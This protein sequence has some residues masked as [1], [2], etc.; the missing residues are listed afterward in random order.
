MVDEGQ[1]LTFQ[2]YALDPHDPTYQLPTRNPDGSLTPPNDVS[3]IAYTVSGL[4]SGASYDPQTATFN[5]T[6]SYT[7]A[8]QYSI[9]VTATDGSDN[10]PPLST[11][12]IIPISVRIVDRSPQITPISNVKVN[13]GQTLDVPVTVSDPNGQA[14]TLTASNALTNAPLPGFVTFTDNGNGTGDFH[15][16]PTIYEPGNYSIV[17]SATDTGGSQGPGAAL[18]STYTFVV[19]VV[20]PNAPP[21]LAPINGQVA[22]VG[23]TFS[24]TTRASD[25]YQDALGYS[26]SGLPSSATLKPGVTYGTAVL[27]W[28]PTSSQTGS[29]SVTVTVTD[30]T[31]TSSPPPSDSQTFN[32]VVVTTDSAPVVT[33]PGNQS[34]A[35][36]APLNLQLQ[37]SDTYGNPVT[38]IATGLPGG[39]IL[40]PNTG[41]IT[42]AAAYGQAGTYPVTVSASDGSESSNA[43]FTITA[44]H[45]NRAPIL[46]PE[47]P[48]YGRENTGLSFNVAG[49]DP[50]G[51]AV[52]L[53]ASNLPAGATFNATTGAFQWTP[54]FGQAGDYTVTFTMTDQG[55]LSDSILVPIHIDH[56][57]RPPIL[58]IPDHQATLGQLLIFSAA[59]TNPNVGS[60]LT[61]SAQGLPQ[62]ASL[63]PNTGLVSWIPGPAQAGDY[64]VRFTASD[65]ILSTTQSVLIE[66]AVTPTP[67]SVTIVLSPNYPVA[68]GTV[69]TVHAIASSVAPITGVTLTL[70]GQ[71]VT[72]DATGKGQ[73]TAGPPG[74]MNLQAVATDADG[75]TGSTTAVLK[76]LDPTDTTAPVVSLDPSLSQSPL[77]SVTTVNGTVAGGNLD[78]WSLAMATLGSENF[79]T[80]A[81]GTAPVSDG[82]LAQ[83]DP[84]TLANGFY[85][86]QLT[87]T[88]IAGLR[89]VTTTQIEVDTSSKPSAVQ[90]GDTDLTVTLDGTTVNLARAYNS[91]APAGVSSFGPG[92]SLVSRDVF[93]Q[94]SL[95]PTG[96]ESLGVYP[97]MQQGTR[98][99]LT[100]PNGTRAGFTF[101]PVAVNLPDQPSNLTY[102]YPAWQADTGV[103]YQL[104]S[105]KTLLVRGGN[106][107][108]DQATGRSYNPSDPFFGPTGYTLTAPDDSQE[109][110]GA[111]GIAELI[112]ASG[113][114]LRVSSSG[115]TAADGETIRFVEGAQGRI[116]AA[117]APSGETINYVYATTGQLAEVVSSTRGVLYRYGYDATLGTLNAAARAAGG[118]RGVPGRPAAPGRAP[119]RRFRRC[120]TVR[121]APHRPEHAQGRRAGLLLLLQRRR[122]PQHQRRQRHC[123]R[124]HCAKRKRARGRDA[125][126][127]RADAAEPLRRCQP[128]RRALRDNA[129]RHLFAA[130]HRC[131]AGRPRRLHCE[132]GCGGRHQRRRPRGRHG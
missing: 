113:S 59:G 53:T 40:N 78:S 98:L 44:T 10:N 101:E 45:T 81:T 23:D 89:S 109:L 111:N 27:T 6:P 55:G 22:L 70:N 80:I 67:P 104:S 94:T 97:A 75:L 65:G 41:A 83:I 54:A 100:L 12:I 92:W 107:Y 16:A 7:Q 51:D 32:L 50:D 15:F 77:T 4:P 82:E 19:T 68:Q 37:A 60:T 76:I 114:V 131:D 8:G 1:K 5:W 33:A 21:L 123:A 48:Q 122:G 95:A 14:L 62:G 69:V 118:K 110:I 46:V 34:V 29:Y 108:Y 26:L 36:G 119:H 121:P 25:I 88:S 117:Q 35:E 73:I 120:G 90:V 63:D 24:L 2:T 115:I 72:L 13:G 116:I 66:A 126:R 105:V 43:S 106:D 17:L 112:T 85:V 64:V 91:I 9:T 18:T 74:L 84:S 99:Y 58:D 31:N 3:P 61:Y 42:W 86:L 130:R 79:T 20:S 127:G 11:T 49:A 103:T 57:D 39:A 30:T 38:W 87:A 102:F 52:T 96:E 129:R 132:R 128:H 124:C 125:R 56:V 71:P 47:P 28:T 93:L